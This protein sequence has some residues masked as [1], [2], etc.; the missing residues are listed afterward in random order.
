M[1]QSWETH[2]RLE[3]SP[4]VP[5][6]RQVAS[7]VV[8]R[9]GSGLL[10]PGMALPGTRS[11]AKSLGVHRNTVKAAYDEL[12]AD[13]WVSTAP[14][15]GTFIAAE[16][17]RQQG[18]RDA[19]S[20]AANSTGQLAYRRTLVCND[21]LHD[22]KLTPATE[23]GRALRRAVRSPR[24]WTE[25]DIRGH[26]GLRAAIA[27]MLRSNRAIAATPEEILITGGRRISL[28]MVARALLTEGSTVAIEQPGNK[29]AWEIFS[30]C[31]LRV[32]GVP[33]DAEGL[34]V[35][36][37]EA[38]GKVSAVYVTPSRQYPTA[39]S[40]PLQR[41]ER[42]VSWCRK[43]GAL[44]IEDDSDCE[45]EFDG[46]PMPA[47]ASM[48]TR[49]ATIHIGTISG[50]FAPAIDSGY[51][52]APRSSTVRLA[53]MGRLAGL[54]NDRI[55]EAALFDLAADGVLR[56]YLRRVRDVYRE[57]RDQ[58]ALALRKEFGCRLRFD[59]P[60][61]GLAVWM[62]PCAE[63]DTRRWAAC[64]HR[65][66]VRFAPA[67]E[68]LLDRSPMGGIRIGFA[69]FSNEELAAVAA[70]LRRSFPDG[71]AQTA[72]KSGQDD[73]SQLRRCTA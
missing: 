58:F 69:T 73:G 17:A 43:T 62:T 15:R 38:C 49:V 40:M 30:Q 61:G 66:G 28:C 37:L 65:L 19:A 3:R 68:Y 24:V 22:P 11:L 13:G 42:L 53:R 16:L 72:A 70:T 18:G 7:N 46:A 55:V 64:A 59:L 23:L 52:R 14:S 45:F 12:L 20:G 41:R 35:D 48:D 27:E 51:I 1:A 9:V 50:M 4:G 29:A 60:G 6:Y 21:G 2:F 26:A 32:V 67:T 39:V 34:R 33:V 36:C 8:K 25:A 10:V 44:I 31:G 56:R 63:I 57:R 54:C 5:L 47:L 71:N